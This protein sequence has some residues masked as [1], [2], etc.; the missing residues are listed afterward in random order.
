MKLEKETCDVCPT[1]G[2][3]RYGIEYAVDA[4]ENGS[5]WVPSADPEKGWNVTFSRPGKRDRRSEEALLDADKKIAELAADLQKAETVATIA[6]AERKQLSELT[7]KLREDLKKVKALAGKLGA[8][9][10][11]F[12]ETIRQ[13]EQDIDE[14]E[15]IPFPTEVPQP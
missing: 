1:C 5:G 13:V 7:R 4:Y 9:D 3:N 11:A 6:E 2:L 8:M 10:V 12:E 14:A 15:L